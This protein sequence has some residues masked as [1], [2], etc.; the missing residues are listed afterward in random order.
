MTRE[1]KSY[2]TVLMNI[3]Y[4]ECC[5][6]KRVLMFKVD[7]LNQELAPEYTRNNPAGIFIS[8]VQFLQSRPDYVKDRSQ[9]IHRTILRRSRHID[10]FLTSTNP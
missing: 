2:I 8:I 1:E 6:D 5:S 10:R 9:I 4:Y 3:K 7:N